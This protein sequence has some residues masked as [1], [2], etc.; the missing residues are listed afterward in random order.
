MVARRHHYVPKLHL[1]TFAVPR[2]KSHQTTVFDRGKREPFTTA[3]DNVAAERDFNRIEL[4]GYAPDAFENGMAAV[5]GE[6]SPAIE[7]IGSTGAF[8]DDDDRACLL[9][10]IGLLHLRNPPQREAFR[11]FQE[12]VAKAT[13]ELVTSTPERWAHQVKK[14]TEA[15]YLKPDAETDYEK[16]KA[17]IDSEE[18]TVETPTESHILR[19]METLDKVLP[20]LFNR[21][22]VL[23]KAPK[24]SGGFITSDHPV[25]LTRSEPAKGPGIRPLGLGLRGTEI[26]FPVSPRIVAI[27]AFELKDGTYE[28]DDIMAAS[29]NGTIIAFAE[30]QVYARDLHFTYC[31]RDGMPARKAS[32]LMSDRQFLRS[33]D[34]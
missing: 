2:K 11:D 4:D 22:W 7:R 16:M 1:K 10:L 20:Y 31:M 9:N 21:G 34:E 23:V 5:E 30:R 19:E 17:F 32:R 24:D 6:L 25:C 18:Y 29:I 27:G 12:R 8:R 15:G 3:I 33:D 26:V 14:A 28:A 13:M